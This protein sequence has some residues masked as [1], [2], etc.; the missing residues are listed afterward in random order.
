MENKE[1]KSENIIL[2][3]T[4]SIHE[5]DL[6]I[7]RHAKKA[8]FDYKHLENMVNILL[9][10]ELKKVNSFENK[11]DRDYTIFN[12]LLNPIVMKAVISNNG[13]GEKTKTNIELIN[14][15]FVDN[16]IFIAL[17]NMGNIL[18]DKNISMIIRRLKKDWT[19]IFKRREEYFKDKSSFTGEPRFPKAKSLAKT[20]QY[21]IPLE[22]SKFSLKR[23]NVLGLT[24]FKKQIHTRFKMNKYVNSKNI[25]SLV[26]S[27]SHGHIYYNFTYVETTKV[28]ALNKK[29]KTFKR[30]ECGLDIGIKN[31]ASLFINDKE[32]QSLIYS[33]SSFIHY[34]VYFNKQLAKINEEIA[35]NVIEYKI[36]K[37]NIKIPILY[38]SKGKSLI[39]ERSQLHEHRN[40][41]FDGEM[42]K[43]SKQLLTYLQK[44]QVTD[45]VISKNLSFT[46]ESGEIKMQKKDKQKFYQ[47]PFGKLLNLIEAKAQ[48]FNINVK[49]IDE[50]YTSKTSCLTRDVNKNQEKRRNGLQVVPTDL[51]GSR[52]TKGSKLGRGIFKDKELNLIFNSDLNGA[53]NHIKVG[54]PKVKISRFRNLIWKVCSPKKV[55]STNE[56]DCFLIQ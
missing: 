22:E 18:N 10:N 23:K 45:L 46:K 6:K 21:S 32:T 49:D 27:Y 17:K 35:K 19:N 39:K 54:F 29:Q 43:I 24:L 50:A 33:G 12:L 26:V 42:N 56:L 48:K 5:K 13:G 1:E 44:N 51:N 2:H 15:Y 4:F 38:N 36:L 8:I 25:Q 47:I 14:N 55:K 41:Y 28:N 34:N 30:K 11:D 37:N 16:K 31:I 52:G 3:K 9:N 20:Y 53:A 7:V 40:R